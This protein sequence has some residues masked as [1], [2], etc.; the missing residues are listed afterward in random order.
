MGHN[1]KEVFI[2]LCTI[3]DDD[4]EKEHNMV[5]QRGKLYEKNQMAVLTFEEQTEEK[6]WIKNFITIQPDKVTIKRTGN[7]M[8]NQQ[9]HMQRATESV[10]KHPYGTM[11]METFTSSITH[12]PLRTDQNGQLKIAYS[13]KL[14]GKEKR[15]H[16]LTLTYNEEGA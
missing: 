9:F 12:Q 15:D 3:I 2:E 4:G 7:V 11:H 13:V 14:N 16:Y 10:F 6:A 5:R 8:M 1:D